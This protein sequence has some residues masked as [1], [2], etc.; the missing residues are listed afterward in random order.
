LKNDVAVI[1]F[2]FMEIIT[3]MSSA[4]D[5]IR[6]TSFSS[7]SGLYPNLAEV[8]IKL[9]DDDALQPKPDPKLPL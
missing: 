3:N 5:R 4:I 7:K 9:S 6:D 8:L 1:H 2:N